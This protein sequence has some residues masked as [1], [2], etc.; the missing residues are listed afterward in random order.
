MPIA[1]NRNRDRR[2]LAAFQGHGPLIGRVIPMRRRDCAAELHVAAQIELV[3]DV[4]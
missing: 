3:G 1:V 4:V 2:L